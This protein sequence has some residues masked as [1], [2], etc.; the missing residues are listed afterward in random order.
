MD[1]L[2]MKL[3]HRQAA[4]NTLP[5]DTVTPHMVPAINNAWSLLD[6]HYNNRE[7]K[8]FYN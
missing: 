8:E 1:E 4:Y 2:L 6:M 7:E 5:S 3:E